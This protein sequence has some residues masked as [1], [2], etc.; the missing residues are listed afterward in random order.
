MYKESKQV[1][2]SLLHYL[3]QHHEIISKIFLHKFTYFLSTQG[4]PLGLRFEPYT[5]GPYSFDLAKIIRD[6]E[7]W[8]EVEDKNNQ[9]KEVDLNSYEPFS[10]E[11]AAL[12]SDRLTDFKKIVGKL[13]FHNL[14]LFGTVLY[15][16][17]VLCAS[18][19]P[20]TDDA[21]LEEFYSWKGKRYSENEIISTFRKVK[22]YVMHQEVA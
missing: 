11:E 6:M 7:F 15:C 5:Y 8:D 20:L 12:I 17:D 22:P 14:E 3:T 19:H 1:V 4:I 16:A 21:I 2:G 10:E 18:G 9:I 13:T